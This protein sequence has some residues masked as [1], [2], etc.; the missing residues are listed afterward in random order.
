MEEIWKPIA[1]NPDYQV[2]NLGRLKGK[3]GAVIRGSYDKDG[4]NVLNSQSKGMVAVK[5]HRAV[6]E[7]FVGAIPNGMVVNHK[8]GIKSDNH[9]DNLEIVTH[10]ENTKHGF[11][12][13]GR[14]GRWHPRKAA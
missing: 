10:S 14:V 13:L 4:Y 9:I 1:S 7:A 8:N 5:V 3:R 2:S 12:H 11:T 6:V